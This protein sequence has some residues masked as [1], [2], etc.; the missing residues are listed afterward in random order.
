MSYYIGDVPNYNRL[1]RAMEGVNIVVH[2]T[3]PINPNG[4]AK[5]KKLS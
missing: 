5:D 4:V 2:T 3:A 1:K